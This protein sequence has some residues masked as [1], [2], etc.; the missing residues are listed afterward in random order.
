MPYTLETIETPALVIDDATLE[1]NLHRM[2]GLVDRYSVNLRPHVKTHKIPEIAHRQLDAGAIGIAVAKVAEAEVMA[3]AGITDIQ[4]A[5]QVVGSSKI[6]RLMKLN[7]MHRVTCAV[8]SVKLVRRLSSAADET[9]QSLRI[10]IEI[11]SGLH[12]CG[13]QDYDDVKT[14]ADE[15]LKSDRLELEGIMTHAGHAY[16]ANSVEEVERIGRAEGELMVSMA[17]RLR[18]DG[19]QVAV[20]SVGSTPT[21]PY[22][23]Q[24][25]GVTELR[26]G[27][28]VFNDMIQVSGGSASL[29]DCAL[30][31]V[32]TVISVPSHTRAVIDAGSKALGLDKGAHGRGGVTGHGFILNKR[33]VISRLSEEHGVLEHEGESFEIG[34]RLRI[35]PNH[36]CAVVNLF[37]HVW[38]AGADDTCTQLAVAARG[39]ST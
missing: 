20:V 6:E 34:E 17:E 21:A 28:Y 29:D 3:D 26:A 2:Q 38:L 36:A 32:A 4:I 9:A 39:R 35:I 25:S 10:L 30:S 33:G 5:N 22:A 18:S 13:L 16:G 23:V 1:R 8:D 15:I 7:E 24:V 12:R 37:D 27:N 14:V 31:V 11:D 19:H